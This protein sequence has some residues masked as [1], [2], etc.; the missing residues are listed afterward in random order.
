M[1]ADNYAKSLLPPL[2]SP[3]RVA[4]IEQAFNKQI[5]LYTQD[6]VYRVHAIKRYRCYE[7]LDVILRR[8]DD[9]TDGRASN[10]EKMQSYMPDG[11]LRGWEGTHHETI[12]AD[13]ASA[14]YTAAYP[15]GAQP[16]AVRE[17]DTY[18][19]E[20]MYPRISEHEMD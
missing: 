11:R 1:A 4:D 15:R 13:A 5:P 2:E 8:V 6:G 12:V 19:R 10:A 9:I 16:D 3:V 18:L 17:R 7:L 20:V 14:S